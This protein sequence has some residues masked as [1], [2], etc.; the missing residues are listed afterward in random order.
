MSE[1]KWTLH[2][3]DACEF[4]RSLPADSVDL[5]VTDPAYCSLEKHRAVGATTRLVKEWFPVVPN[6]YYPDFF[7]AC[8]YTLKKNTHLYM[9]CDDETAYIVKPLA[10]AQGFK[11]HKRLVWDKMKIGM[12][13]HYRARC[14]Y[15]LFFEKGKR[16][17]NNLGMPDV[18]D[19]KEDPEGYILEC[20]RI[21]NGYP[22]QKP[23]SVSAKLICQ[24]SAPG[25]LIV[26]PFCGSSSVGV[27]AIQ[28]ERR[29]IGNDIMDAAIKTST[30]QLVT[31]SELSLKQGKLFE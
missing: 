7:C 11:Y 23:S 13:Y 9:Y 26:D 30:E 4:L 6:T 27:A 18:F 3:R 22:T 28:N 25:E 24:S 12:G 19:I 5:I 10:E 21:R 16:K 29:Y 8:Y 15:I 1:A 17:L 31:A 2:Q 20:A 14:E